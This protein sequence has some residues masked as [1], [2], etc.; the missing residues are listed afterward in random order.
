MSEAAGDLPAFLALSAENQR[1]AHLAGAAELGRPAIVLEKDFWVC[2][3]LEAL[4]SCP[5]IPN[6]AFKGGT[7]LSKTFGAISRFSEDIDV[8]IDHGG[9][10]PGL[11]PYDPNLSGGQRRRDNDTLLGALLACSNDV[12]VP[13]LYRQLEVAGLSADNLVVGENG[14]ELTVQYPHLVTDG[15]SYYREGVKIEF[16]GRNMIEPNQKHV[17]TPYMVEMLDNFAFPAGRVAVLAPER[18]FW[19][20]FTLAHAESNREPMVT[21]DRIS[22]HWHNLAVLADHEIGQAALAD[23]GLLEDVVKVKE[24]FYRRATS[25]YS[26]CLAGESCLLPGAKGLALLRADYEEMLGAEMLDHPITFD[27]V[28]ERVRALEADANGAISAARSPGQ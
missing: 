21:G 23:I 20:K 5:G 1:E 13:H 2:W 18:T 26:Q 16:G 22:R 28:I 10:V 17:V 12:I 6:M 3:T 11:D 9:L 14:A 8:T 25:Q 24:R 19:E 7:S 27:E 4:F 15:A